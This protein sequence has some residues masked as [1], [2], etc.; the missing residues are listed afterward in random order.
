MQALK[1]RFE[2]TDKRQRIEA[3]RRRRR[4]VQRNREDKERREDIEDRA[5]DAVAAFSTAVSVSPPAPP[6]RIEEFET[7][8]TAFDIAVVEVLIENDQRLA[9]LNDFIDV[10]LAEA[11][12]L[13]DGRRVFRSEDGT[14]VIDEF[15]QEVSPDEVHPDEIDPDAPSWE[16]FSGRV[17]ERDALLAERE[18]LLEFQAEL[19]ALESDLLDNMPPAVAR[20]VDGIDIKE[21]TQESSLG[22]SQHAQQATSEV[23]SF[24]MFIPR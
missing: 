13:E 12:V 11:F 22:P 24:D 18:D 17:Q 2:A 8:L 14:K 3:D 9:A 5:D 21:A 20:L 10:M 6:D 19:D 15:G 7:T 1:Y 16:M 23:G 4:E